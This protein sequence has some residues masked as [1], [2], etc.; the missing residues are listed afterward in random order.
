DGG[1]TFTKLFQTATRANDQ[2]S[3]AIGPSGLPGLPGSV[4]IVYTDSSGNIVTHGAIVLGLGAVLPFTPP[5]MAPRPGGDY[6][7]IA[8]GPNGQVMVTYQSAIGSTGPDT[9]TVNLDA[10]GLG[11]AGFG[12]VVNATTTQVG[13]MA[14]LP[15]QPDRP[16]DAEAGLTWDRT[17]GPHNG[18]V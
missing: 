17:G 14:P 16:T 15:A 10:D 7:D 5:E 11:T 18:R 2:P 12:P 8:I 4:W 3:V 13:D 9:I 6:G 1:A